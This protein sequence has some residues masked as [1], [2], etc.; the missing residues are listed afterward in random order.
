M[1]NLG[2][3]T[4]AGRL[5]S[6]LDVLVLAELL[7]AV[8]AIA[9][10]RFWACTPT[11]GIRDPI[12]IHV[13]FHSAACP[14]HPLICHSSS[15][16]FSFAQYWHIIY[17]IWLVATLAAFRFIFAL[18]I[19]YGLVQIKG[20]KI[21]LKVRKRRGEGGSEAGIKCSY[22]ATAP[23]FLKRKTKSDNILIDKRWTWTL[24]M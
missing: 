17:K 7:V 9:R 14:L 19:I 1:R 20:F 23:F 12:F 2:P 3:R 11:V 15:F 10:V 8:V 13:H 18:D 21:Y 5:H 22:L 24:T 16:S 4:F 6:F